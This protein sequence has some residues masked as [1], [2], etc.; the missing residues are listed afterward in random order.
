MTTAQPQSRHNSSTNIAGLSPLTSQR[1][2]KRGKQEDELAALKQEQKEI[3]NRLEAAIRSG[4]P[5]KKPQLVVKFE[6]KPD[7]SVPLSQRTDHSTS[8]IKKVGPSETHKEIDESGFELSSQFDGSDLTN[9]K[10]NQQILPK[11]GIPK[12][13][14]QIQTERHG[15]QGSNQEEQS[16]LISKNR[17]HL[18]ASE[19][20]MVSSPC[21]KSPSSAHEKKSKRIGE[22][23]GHSRKY[24]DRYWNQLSDSLQESKEAQKHSNTTLHKRNLAQVVQ[25]TPVEHR[26]SAEHGQ[27]LDESMGI[28]DNISMNSFAS[29]QIGKITQNLL[30][31]QEPLVTSIRF[32]QVIQPSKTDHFR[33]ITAMSDK[34]TRL[35]KKY[36]ISPAFD[37]LYLA[38]T[39]RHRQ[40]TRAEKHHRLHTLHRTLT[41]WQQAI[42]TGTTPTS[43]QSIAGTPELSHPPQTP[44]AAPTPAKT[45]TNPTFSPRTSPG[46]PVSTPPAANQQ[47]PQPAVIATATTPKNASNNKVADNNVNGYMQ[48]PQQTKLRT[49]RTPP[50]K[51]TEDSS[52]VVVKSV[53]KTVVE[54]RVEKSPRQQSAR[55]SSPLAKTEIAN[56]TSQIKNQIQTH[57]Q[58]KITNS[59]PQIQNSQGALPLKPSKKPILSSTKP[60]TETGP[61]GQRQVPKAMAKMKDQ[62]SALESKLDESKFSSRSDRSTGASKSITFK[63]LPSNSRPISPKINTKSV[64][65]KRI[66]NGDRQYHTPNKPSD[67]KSPSSSHRETKSQNSSEILV[68]AGAK[69][70]EI[71]RRSPTKPLM[72]AA[73]APKSAKPTK[74]HPAAPTPQRDNTKNTNSRIEQHDDDDDEEEEVENSL[75]RSL[76]SSPSPADRHR[77]PNVSAPQQ[78]QTRSRTGRNLAVGFGPQRHATQQLHQ[79]RRT[80]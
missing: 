14:L 60:N 52:A 33:P 77:R 1:R 62:K 51:T 30:Q 55:N 6:E 11:T 10:W 72:P 32:S 4:V 21:P 47:K 57:N 73:P 25:R 41:Q 13:D 45:T 12:K 23:S 24:S 36:A 48:T 2:Q 59:K 69:P 68:T 64:S 66:I 38:A 58:M 27:N 15:Y 40:N 53:S 35:F 8:Q 65:E 31:V 54:L 22:H 63:V 49:A 43:P 5:N 76:Q 46:R 16:I 67:T 18:E 26:I 71:G 39:K 9:F 37:G 44:T 3:K 80:L 74:P 34:L 56:N 79:V 19:V 78:Q 50:R 28:P 17:T 75:V 20:M 7:P 29:S 70:A 61:I 42:R